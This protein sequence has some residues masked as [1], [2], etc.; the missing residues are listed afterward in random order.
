MQN[1]LFKTITKQIEKTSSTIN[2]YPYTSSA[3]ALLILC[4]RETCHFVRYMFIHASFQIIIQ[5]HGGPLVIQ[6]IHYGIGTI[7]SICFGL[8]E[9]KSCSCIENKSVA[10]GEVLSPVIICIT[11]SLQRLYYLCVAVFRKGE[12]G[13]EGFIY[14]QNTNITAIVCVYIKIKYVRGENRP[15]SQNSC[16]FWMTSAGTCN[17]TL[18]YQ[19][20]YL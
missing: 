5:N 15:P 6:C 18:L 7:G 10:Q 9:W 1:F 8:L 3:Q 20:K 2:N 14:C 4:I 19:Q 12:G 11:S 16:K 17:I 13:G